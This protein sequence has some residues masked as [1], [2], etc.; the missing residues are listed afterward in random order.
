MRRLK[1]KIS[2]L[3]GQKTLIIREENDI[4]ILNYGFDLEDALNNIKDIKNVN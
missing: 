4:N 1:L 2:W 3:K